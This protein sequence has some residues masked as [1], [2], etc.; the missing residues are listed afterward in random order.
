M[1]SKGNSILKYRCHQ[2]SSCLACLFTKEQY[3]IIVPCQIITTVYADSDVYH[4]TELPMAVN[5]TLIV[6][7]VVTVLVKTMTTMMMIF[8]FFCVLP[9][10]RRKCVCDRFRFPTV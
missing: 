2:S 8:F 3:G 6:S 5:T 7:L 9:V 1:N 4:T 10:P